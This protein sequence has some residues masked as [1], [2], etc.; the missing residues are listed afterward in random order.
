MI[1]PRDGARDS[2]KGGLSHSYY[3]ISSIRKAA[4]EALIA[5]VRQRK[6][7]FFDLL[8]ILENHDF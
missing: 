7:F 2:Y 6:Q 1:V 8:F 3:G 5:F 4:V